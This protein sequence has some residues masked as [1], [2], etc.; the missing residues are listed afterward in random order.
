MDQGKLNPMDILRKV[1]NAIEVNSFLSYVFDKTAFVV[2][3]AENSLFKEKMFDYISAISVLEHLQ[4]DEKAMKN[5]L[6]SLKTEGYIYICVP[7]AY[8]RMWPFLWPI[9]YYYDLKIGHKRHYSI[10][11][12]DDYFVNKFG[13][14]KYKVFYNGHLLKFYQIALEKLKL[15]DGINWWKMEEKD[16]NNQDSGVQ[17]NTIYQKK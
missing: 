13:C 1:K 15:I 4:S 3:T 9:Y 10:E 7:N 8:L 5:I 11:K 14:K 12:L 16:I 2:S 6:Y 17:L